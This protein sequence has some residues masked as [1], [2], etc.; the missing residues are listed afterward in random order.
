MENLITPYLAEIKSL[1]ETI[2][3]NPELSYKEFETTNLIEETLNSWGVKFNRFNKLETG[4]YCDI[5]DGEII[6]F[7]SD[8]DALPITEDP[9]HEIISNNI[10]IMHACGHDYHTAFGLGLAKYYSEN[11]PDKKI[12]IIFQPA[13]EAAPGGAEFVIKENV[14][15]NV[16]TA[17]GI[18]VDPIKPVGKFD[19]IEGAVQASTTSIKIK[20]IGPGGHTSKP[21]ETVDLINVASQFVVQVQNYLRQNIDPRETLAF[22]FGEISGGSTHNTIPQEVKLRGTLRTHSNEVLDKCL[23][24][25]P[26]FSQKFA[27][28]QNID[29][30]LDFPTSCPATINDIELTNKFINFI[31]N[32]GKE[33]DLIL[34]SKPSM[35]ADDFAFYG[36]EVPSL[37]LQVGAAGKGTLH[38]KDLEIN[39][40]VL[41]TSIN[42][43]IKFINKL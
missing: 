6:V 28:L 29:I 4:G 23:K 32:D 42:T 33:E 9:S 11:N 15:E 37:Y 14:L 19:V 26:S 17:I 31:K 20:L 39:E 2:H 38:S 36:I 24:L 43:L 10:G 35:G 21:S 27:Q 7:R 8:I 13:E 30:N 41:E 22:A 3:R 12:R 5:G 18:H 34:N 16:S 25:M 1:R 40:N